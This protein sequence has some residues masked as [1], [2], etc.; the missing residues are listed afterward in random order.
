M[1]IWPGS[2]CSAPRC[3]DGCAARRNADHQPSQA[4]RRFGDVARRL[5]V[6]HPARQEQSGPASAD[7]LGMRSADHNQQGPLCPLAALDGSHRQ[8]AGLGVPSPAGDGDVAHDRSLHGNVNDG[9]RP[10]IG[11]EQDALLKCADRQA[12]S[13]G[14]SVPDSRLEPLPPLSIARPRDAARS[15]S[16]YLP[17]CSIGQLIAGDFQR[18][19]QVAVHADFA[20][21]RLAEPQGAEGPTAKA[22]PPPD[23]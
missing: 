4:D 16:K 17:H 7:V 22:R 10:R 2:P 19:L 8:H 21:S 1:V 20:R 5:Q 13:H 9:N 3:V 18:L 23:P 14:D 11:L 15:T 12:R 6:R